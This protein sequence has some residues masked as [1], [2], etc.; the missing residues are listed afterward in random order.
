MPTPPFS[1]YRSAYIRHVARLAETSNLPYFLSHDGQ[2]ATRAREIER[3]FQA[4]TFAGP[5]AMWIDILLHIRSTTFIGN[6][7]SS[8]S[9]NIWGIR[10]LMAPGACCDM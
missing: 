3:E 10:K 1:T 4:V 2:N 8:L 6:I 7:A 9:G 5:N